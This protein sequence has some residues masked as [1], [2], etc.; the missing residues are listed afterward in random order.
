MKHLFEPDIISYSDYY[1]FGWTMPGREGLSDH[2]R[3]GFNGMERDDEV[4]GSGNS[5][6]FGARIY[7]S[8]VGRWL[9]TDALGAKYPGTSPY[10]FVRNN[11]VWRIDP[12]GNTDYTATVRSTK[13]QSTGVI[14]KTV[15]VEIVY[16]VVNLSSTKNYLTS[17]SLIPGHNSNTFSTEF[18]TTN[19]YGENVQMDVN[20][21]V[22]F[23][24]VDDFSKIN[25]DQNV[26]FLVDDVKKMPGDL[27]QTGNPIGRATLD[28]QVAA[29]EA[30]AG[31]NRST[32]FH[33]LGHNLG[34]N[35]PSNADDPAHS[36]QKGHLM[37]FQTGGNK[38]NSSEL[39]SAW[40]H[41]SNLI[42]GTHQLGGGEA[43]SNA[44]DFINSGGYEVNRAKKDE[45]NTP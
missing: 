22:R 33:E 29:V 23:E 21:N 18:S 32:I 12:D 3:Y 10:G 15:S 4:K 7:D 13:D 26:L 8:R 25:N 41:L 34:L 9:S 45:T 17:G 40:Q 44:D 2:Y 36:S 38:L 14:K 5:M 39:K 6:D 11:P 16:Q 19:A 31:F 27:E 35:F 37:Y 1:P 20:V 42:D 30:R 24:V 43:Q 28:G